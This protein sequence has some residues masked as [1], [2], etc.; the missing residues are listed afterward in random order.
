MALQPERADAITCGPGTPTDGAREWAP[1]PSGSNGVSGGVPRFQPKG[2]DVVP[3]AT[4]VPRHLD[5]GTDQEA[6]GYS[7]HMATP[8]ARSGSI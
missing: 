3:W 1:L 8:A 6:P 4:E 2:D 5:F 7:P